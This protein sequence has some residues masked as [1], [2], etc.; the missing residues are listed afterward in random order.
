MQKTGNLVVLLLLIAVLT[1]ISAG[2]LV[3]AL[4]VLAIATVILGVGLEATIVLLAVR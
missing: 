1:F 4:P 2:L 3:S